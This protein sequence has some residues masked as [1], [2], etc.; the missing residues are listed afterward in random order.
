MSPLPRRSRLLPR[1]LLPRILPMIILQLTPAGARRGDTFFKACNGVNDPGAQN[2][3]LSETSITTSVETITT[4]GVAGFTTYQIMIHL[5][6]VRSPLPLLQLLLLLLLQLLL[7]LLPQLLL[8]LLLQLLL[9]LLLLLLLQLLL[10][11][12]ALTPPHS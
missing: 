10:Q 12:L 9:L 7:L 4:S 2:I 8:L 6:D 11:L 3:R 5:S 1:I